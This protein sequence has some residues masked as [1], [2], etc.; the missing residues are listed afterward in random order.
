[1]RL[2]ENSSPSEPSG[3]CHI[4]QQSHT[5]KTDFILKNLYEGDI[6]RSVQLRRN[7]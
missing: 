6:M 4:L 3:I 1:M 2:D 5:S 7:L